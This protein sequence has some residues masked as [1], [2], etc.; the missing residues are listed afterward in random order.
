MSE[1][2]EGEEAEQIARD[3]ETLTSE[4]TSQKPRSKWWELSI[5]GLKDAAKNVGEIGKPVIELA[6]HIAVILSRLS[7][8]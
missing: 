2:L 6:S 3:L 4:A 1:G 5:E 7:T 8:S